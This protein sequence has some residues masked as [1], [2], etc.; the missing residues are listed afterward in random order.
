[1]KPFNAEKFLAS[2][3]RVV[4]VIAWLI[5]CVFLLMKQKP[6]D[7]SLQLLVFPEIMGDLN[8][9]LVL[10]FRVSLVLLSVFLSYRLAIVHFEVSKKDL[11][12]AAGILMAH[13]SISDQT[14]GVVAALT[15]V[16]VLF[17][18]LMLLNQDGHVPYLRN[19][20]SAGLAGGLMLLT[21][22]PGLLFFPASV[23]I[24]I[25][26][27]NLSIRSFFVL[28]TG[29]LMP[30]SY[31]LFYYYLIDFWPFEE[32]AMF[33]FESIR[34]AFPFLTEPWLLLV[35]FV[36]LWVALMVHF[37]SFEF[38]ISVRRS[39]SSLFFAVITVFPTLIFYCDWFIPLLALLGLTAAIYW[40]K[41]LLISRSRVAFIFL[42]VLSLAIP[43]LLITLPKL[44]QSA[45]E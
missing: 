21:G 36:F 13:L 26:Q 10:V 24:L 16:V 19:V 27:Q 17:V 8:E 34:P 15:F 3:W 2:G 42:I 11:S 39:F 14:N 44:I 5:M 33:M 25:I 37:R 40:N 29:Y 23:L 9:S 28:A 32:N 30:L 31:V 38:K 12:L 41:A 45:I 18:L 1:M 35:P 4:F 20:V 43:F 7:G 6:A 22:L